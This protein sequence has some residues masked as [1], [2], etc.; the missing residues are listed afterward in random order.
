[1]CFYFSPTMNINVGIKI[2]QISTQWD[3]I[4]SRV[5]GEGSAAAFS[6]PVGWS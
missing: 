2:Q 4:Q 6:L 5:C 3:V 1:M